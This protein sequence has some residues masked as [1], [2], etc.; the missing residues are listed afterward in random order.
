MGSSTAALPILAYTPVVTKRL[1]LR[2]ETSADLEAVYRMH[3]DPQVMRFIADGS[4]C[5]VPWEEFR[6][7]ALA[8]HLKQREL[9]YMNLSVVRAVDGEYLGW[10]GLTAEPLTSEVQLGYRFCQRAWGFGYA[11]E[12]ASAIIAL[13]FNALALPRVVA[14]VHA[15]NTASCRVMAKL[16][17]HH[18]RD[19]FHP[20]AGRQVC[21]YFLERQ[22]WEA[23][24]NP[25]DSRIRQ[26]GKR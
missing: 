11:T 12:A 6:G 20:R 19:V 13:A 26:I 21:L 17:M 7:N 14:T 9:Q 18:E 15:D 2:A 5:A 4:V 1:I 23:L 3:C 16:G 25:P 24:H 8:M 22:T 10:C